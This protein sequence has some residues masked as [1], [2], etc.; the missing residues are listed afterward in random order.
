MID[1][2]NDLSNKISINRRYGCGNF[3]IVNPTIADVLLDYEKTQLR[4]KKL[5]TIL[6]GSNNC[7]NGRK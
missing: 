2:I 1:K 6:Y 5:K 7:S 4:I 3:L